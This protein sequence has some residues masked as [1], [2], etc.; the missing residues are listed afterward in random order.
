[1]I[2]TTDPIVQ[3]PRRADVHTAHS[4][5]TGG[6][7]PHDFASIHRSVRGAYFSPNLFYFPHT[8]GVESQINAWHPNEKP[9]KKKLHA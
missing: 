2:T 3:T 4:K 9:S 1:M 6:F 7:K 8:N 5:C